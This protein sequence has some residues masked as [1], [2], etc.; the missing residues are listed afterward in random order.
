MDRAAPST[1][2]IPTQ[3]GDALILQTESSFTIYVVGR[4]SKDGQQDFDG[5]TNL[6]YASDRAAAVAAARAL[7]QS[8]GGQIFLRNIDNGV[9]SEL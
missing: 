3:R 4:V 5:Q 9:W 1:K 8:E 7:V 6:T 2:R